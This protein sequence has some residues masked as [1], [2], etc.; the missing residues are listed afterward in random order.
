V[1][2]DKQRVPWDEA[3]EVL[4][5][6]L[7]IAAVGYVTGP[8]V[9][10]LAVDSQFEFWDDLRVILSNVNITTGLLL[11]AAAITICVP[12]REDTVPALRRSVWVVATIVTVLGIV[13]MINVLTARSAADSVFLR[14][15]L[16]LVASGPGTLLA[17]L[18]AWL[19]DRVDVATE[20]N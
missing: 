10:H 16:V 18:A 3:R 13:A 20:P 9:R 6:V 2:D 7:L 19:V 11:I 17:G 1:S 12:P 15:S 5:M 4:S 8:L 14:I